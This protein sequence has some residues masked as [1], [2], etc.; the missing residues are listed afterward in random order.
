[1]RPPSYCRA[2]PAG[3]RNQAP[4]DAGWRT[5]IHTPSLNT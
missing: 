2:S 1:V 3:H 5:Y 4:A